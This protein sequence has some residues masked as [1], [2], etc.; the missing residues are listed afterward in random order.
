MEQTFSPRI[1]ATLIHRMGKGATASH[2]ADAVV[3][4]FQDIEASLTPVVGPGGMAALYQRSL[5][6]AKTTFDW[7]DISAELPTSHV[8]FSTLRAL[9]AQQS[10]EAALASG[11]EVLE[12]FSRLL[13]SLIGFSLAQQLLGAVWIQPTAAS[14][15]QDAP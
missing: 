14:P 15:V 10:E 11:I 8:E 1:S 6:L 2:I 5:Y 13:V 3:V 4:V 12:T 9:L 7:I